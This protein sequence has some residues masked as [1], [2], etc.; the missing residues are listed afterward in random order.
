MSLS[1]VTVLHNSAGSL[2]AMIASL[3]RLGPPAPEL[4]CVDSGSRDGGPELA[5]G[6]GARVV[7]MEGNPG[8]GA[9]CNAGIAAASGECCVLLNPDT[10]LVDGGLR[11]LEAAAGRSRAIFAPRLLNPGGSIQDSA[12]PVPGGL[13]SLVGALIPPRLLPQGIRNALEPFRASRP[14]VVGWA[15]GACLVAPTGLLRELGPFDPDEFLYAEDLDL[16]LR[17]RAAGVP[18][19]FRPDVEVIHEGG[20]STEAAIGEARRLEMQAGRRREVISRQLGPGALQRDDLAQAVT[21]ALR[22]AV[23]RRRRANL[24]RLRALR[25][26]QKSPS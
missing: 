2:P 8:F 1:V 5:A 21:F 18:V 10:H 16:C 13:G 17:A 22:A 20:H 7:R 25:E 15:I 4:I 12:H 26:A 11:R 6:L 24:A 3:D 23:G 14:V 9:A 19:V